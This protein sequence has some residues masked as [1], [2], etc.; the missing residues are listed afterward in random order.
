MTSL[1][2]GMHTRA[3][4]MRENGMDATTVCVYKIGQSHF[5][6]YFKQ[7]NERGEQL[8]NPYELN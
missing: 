1:T 8:H 2:P 7:M 3:T 6:G 4:L 5:A